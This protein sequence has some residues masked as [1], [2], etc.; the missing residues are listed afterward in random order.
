[1]PLV[2]SR[3]YRL[4]PDVVGSLSRGMQFGQ[5]VANAPLNRQ[6]LEQRV[7][8]GQQ[9]FDMNQFNLEQSQQAA[10]RQA[11][12]RDVL[13]QFGQQAPQ[14]AQQA[15]LAEQSA[16]FADTGDALGRQAFAEQPKALSQSELIRK[17]RSI[18]P[19]MAN[20]MLKEMGL[21]D[22][23]KREE[24]SR[25]AAK[26]QMMP[27]DAQT[28]EIE[29][30]AAILDR[31]G[32]DSKDTRQLLGMDASTRMQ[33][34]QGVQM[35]D[36]SSKERMTIQ[37]KAAAAQAKLDKPKQ[38]QS[39]S[40]LD[41]GTVQLVYKDG[42]VEIKPA[43]AVGAALVRAGKAY[44]VDLQTQ[45]AQGRQVGKDAGKTSQQAFETT[46]KLRDN[47]QTLQKVI[48]EVTAG[49]NTG[50]LASKLPSFR[51]ESVRLDQLRRKLGLDVIGSVTFGALSEGELQLALD[52]ALPTGLDGP[53]LIQW[54]QDKIDAQE[55][56][57][58]YLENQSIFL[59]EPGN[60]PAK[61]LKKMRDEAPKK[62]IIDVD[63]A[64]LEELKAAKAKLEA[65]N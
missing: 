7:A 44:G 59:S 18:D 10:E 22:A 31:D 55:K 40:I 33:A 64:S 56:M 3:G 65:K 1:M 9:R 12:V 58:T 11:G 32:R 39:S 42:S 19:V 48:N 49:A 13:G 34:L 43:N 50:P 6:L 23:S 29:A 28:Q 45:R 14:T 61:W 63:N 21:D 26:I 62:A 41:D 53:E 35:L 46:T 52:T 20:K 25:F 4:T 51:A 54:A 27:Y 60:T 8:A 38:V 16:E 57:A 15:Q 37:S 36:M 30:R 24:A 5:N 17:A 2:D 47:N